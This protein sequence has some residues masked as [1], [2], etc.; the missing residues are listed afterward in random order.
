MLE[1]E[2]LEGGGGDLAKAVT[3]SAVMGV[4]GPLT[5]LHDAAI[6]RDPVTAQI[7][8]HGIFFAYTEAPFRNSCSQGDNPSYI[9]H[10][11]WGASAHGSYWGVNDQGDDSNGVWPAIDKTD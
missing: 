8:S 4:V 1:G 7:P 2:A 11:Q 3:F 9:W 6:A 10:P 5:T